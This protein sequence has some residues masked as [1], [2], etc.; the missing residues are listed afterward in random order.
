MKHHW[1][2]YYPWDELKSKTLLAS[3]IPD[4]K[5]NFDKNYWESIYKISEETKIRYEEIPNPL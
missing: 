2:K 1:L 4:P 5:N 3:F